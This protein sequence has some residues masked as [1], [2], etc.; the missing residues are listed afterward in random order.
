MGGEIDLRRSGRAPDAEA[1]RGVGQRIRHPEGAQHIRRLHGGG[2]AGGAAGNGE[3]VQGEQQRL[4]IHVGEG[5]VQVARQP[6]RLGTIQAGAGELLQVCPKALPQG[7]DATGFGWHFFSADAAGF[8]QPHDLMGGQGAGTHAALVAAAVD[9]RRHLKRRLAAHEQGADALGA[10]ELMRRQAQ[11]IDVVAP[12][13]HVNLADALRRVGV[14]RHAALATEG[15]DGTDVVQHADL[16]VGMHDGDDGRVVPDGV[17]HERRRDQA[18]R[19]RGEIGDVHAQAFE[20]RAGVQ[21]GLVLV[22]RRHHMLPAHR[23]DHALDGQVVGLGG[24]GGPDDLA[25]VCMDERRHLGARRLDQFLRL[26]TIGVAPGRR[27][28]EGALGQEAL[29]HALRHAGIHGRGGRVIQVQRLGAR[30]RRWHFRSC[31]RQ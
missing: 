5:D 13:V 25:R 20:P 31:G 12:H 8:P 1:N 6:V 24:A 27:I 4:T 2:R 28:A 19:I 30:R 29:A 9:L 18:F 16:V 21:H 11:E 22:T 10:V 7:T 17:R 26:P 23:L 15:A 3:I 14:E